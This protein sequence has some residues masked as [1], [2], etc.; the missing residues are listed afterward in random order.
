MLPKYIVREEG[1]LGGKPHI[2]GHRIGVLHIAWWYLQGMTA[3][4]LAAEYQLTPAEVHAA[5]VYYYD[6]KDEIE[7][8]LADEDTA[9]ATL[10][11]A[12]MSPIA[13]RMRAA[14]AEREQQ[15]QA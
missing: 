14:M 3:E 2:A 9:H 13:E 11:D 7:R 8:E 1:V 6:H 5:L 12:D 10:A 15:M 4:E